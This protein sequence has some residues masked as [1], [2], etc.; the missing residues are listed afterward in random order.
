[1]IIFNNRVLAARDVN[2]NV[3]DNLASF[4]I[5]ILQTAHFYPDLIPVYDKNKQYLLNIVT[6]ESEEFCRSEF[7][8]IEN[9]VTFHVNKDPDVNL[10]ME[11]AKELVSKLY[12]NSG[13]DIDKFLGNF[14]VLGEE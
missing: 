6:D 1:M 9:I 7:S 12:N 5:G 4:L 14:F 10:Y 11:L 3:S 13:P 2:E 8:K